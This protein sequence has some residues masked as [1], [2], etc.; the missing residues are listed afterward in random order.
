LPATN[1]PVPKRARI[2]PAFDSPPARG[3]FETTDLSWGLFPISPMFVLR[4]L[5]GKSGPP[6]PS[7][8]VGCGPSSARVPSGRYR[9]FPGRV[10]SRYGLRQGTVQRKAM[11]RLIYRGGFAMGSSVRFPNI[12]RGPR[13]DIPFPIAPPDRNVWARV[14]GWCGGLLA[15]T[16]LNRP[17]RAALSPGCRRVT[18]FQASHRSPR[19]NAVR[20]LPN[21]FPGRPDRGKFRRAIGSDEGGCLPPRQPRGT[22]PL[23]GRPI[24]VSPPILLVAYCRKEGRFAKGGTG[25]SPTTAPWADRVSRKRGLGPARCVAATGPRA[26]QCPRGSRPK[27]NSAM[28]GTHPRPQRLRPSP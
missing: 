21:V 18:G 15:G 24:P 28:S 26:A 12:P 19:R 9:P 10:F 8:Y 4:F 22:S 14:G 27:E 25:L 20:K 23:V 7:N 13:Q 5:P 17:P 16:R 2:R 11:G 1:C 3:R 6:C